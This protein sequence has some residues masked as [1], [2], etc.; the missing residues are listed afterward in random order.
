MYDYHRHGLDHAIQYL[1]YSYERKPK[2][3]KGL[4]YALSKLTSYSTAYRE[5]SPATIQIKK[6]VTLISGGLDCVQRVL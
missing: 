5:M 3:R 2:R 6:N 1:T 4:D